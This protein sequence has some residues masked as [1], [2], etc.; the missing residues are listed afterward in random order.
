MNGKL[1][2]EDITPPSFR[3]MVNIPS[4]TQRSMENL[5]FARAGPKEERLS[6]FY[7]YALNV[8]SIDDI[9]I[10]YMRLR[11]LQK[12]A[13]HVLVAYSLLHNDATIKQGCAD[14]KEY[15]GD[16]EILRAINSIRAINVAVFVSR[17]YGGVPLGGTR[18][19]IIK[20]LAAQ[21]LQ[22]L[23]P[24]CMPENEFPEELKSKAACQRQPNNRGQA[25]FRGRDRGGRRG[26]GG[27]PRGGP[28]NRGS[29]RG[30]YG[31]LRGQNHNS[32][33]QGR[34]SPN[35]Q[36]TSG[37]RTRGWENNSEETFRKQ[38]WNDNEYGTT[39][40]WEESEDS[41]VLD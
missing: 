24:K 21:L 38:D 9:D 20:E 17:E 7:A 8:K 3:D 16:Q 33:R 22:E 31:P 30:G 40:N 29:G 6:M 27:Q 23:D 25:S 18:F 10:A 26:R 1:I 37:Y 11:Q 14:D 5:E 12:F 19:Q 32:S 28:R 4:Q 41:E 2:E 15:Y 13:D 35:S 39:E 36:S 34:N